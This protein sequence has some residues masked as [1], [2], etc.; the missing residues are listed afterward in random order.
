MRYIEIFLW[1]T[2][3]AWL[4]ELYP[5]PSERVGL[6]HPTIGQ[7]RKSHSKWYHV[8][9]LQSTMR[10]ISVI[11][12]I[13]A[14]FLANLAIAFPTV[15]RTFDSESPNR[16]MSLGIAFTTAS[17]R[18]PV[19]IYEVRQVAFHLDVP[20]L[21]SLAR[22]FTTALRTFESEWSNSWISFGIAFLIEPTRWAV[23]TC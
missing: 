23:V 4:V 17:Q 1:S 15:S 16:R 2:H 5:W 18:S 19:I 20:I 6:V 9:Q 7:T 12:V 8:D 13:Y 10:Y 22:L 11:T 21:A 3:H 14:P